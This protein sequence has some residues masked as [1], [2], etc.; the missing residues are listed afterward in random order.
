[1][2]RGADWVI[3]MGSFAVCCFVMVETASDSY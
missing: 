3:A 2:K 1:M